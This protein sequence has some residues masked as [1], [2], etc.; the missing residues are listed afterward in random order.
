MEQKESNEAEQ[1]IMFHFKV[2]LVF[3][4]AVVV[5]ANK[6]GKP[7]LAIIDEIVAQLPAVE[8]P[9]GEP[10]MPKPSIVQKDVPMVATGYE[11]GGPKFIS[12]AA[13][14]AQM[15]YIPTYAESVRA[16]QLA[17]AEAGARNKDGMQ[18]VMETVLAR[19]ESDEFPNNVI[20]VSLKGFTCIKNGVPCI[21]DNPVKMEEI[22]AY[23][24]DLWREVC[25]G[26]NL[27]EDLL[28]QAAEEKGITDEKYWKDGALYFTQM[29]LIFG[30]ELASRA[31]IRV[32]VKI[33]NGN[34]FYRYWDKNGE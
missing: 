27:T 3:L 30:E 9:I 17:V 7:M 14:E 22:P 2:V 20:S 5:M 33:D 32:K 1:R 16:C 31:A 23:V 13:E 10:A 26:T 18:A 4:L 21:G 19:I 24:M 29:D 34:T 15:R 28:R 6:P 25:K 12:T 8:E 11:Q